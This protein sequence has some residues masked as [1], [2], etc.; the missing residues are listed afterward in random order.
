MDKLRQK[1]A[2]LR[3]TVIFAFFLI[4]AIVVY[5]IRSNIAYIFMF[6]GI[7]LIASFTEYMIAMVPD[8]AQTTRKVSLFF[9]SGILVLLALLIGIN[10]QFSQIFMDL[11]AGIITGALIQFAAARLILPVFFGNIFCSRACWDGAIFELLENKPPPAGIKKHLKYRSTSAW[12]YLLLI[13]SAASLCG[14]TGKLP[15]GSSAIRWVFIVSNVLIITVG[16]L[17]SRIKGSRAYCR[18]LCPFLTV[19]GV[20][21]PFS[22]FKV[23]PVN[24]PACTGCGK[25]T[26]ICPMHINV[27]EY[28]QQEKRISHPDCILCEQCVTSCPA[29]CLRVK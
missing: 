19:S 16:I 27:M 25:C 21:S 13:I 12:I 10:F 6:S 5:F 29:E 22:M 18:K 15:P 23:T 7:G 14:I 2:L 17:A 20:I 9:L 3:G 1:T 4:T 11:Y 24:S 8:Y 28:V 26:I